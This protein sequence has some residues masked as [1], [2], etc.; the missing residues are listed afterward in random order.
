MSPFQVATV[1][2]KTPWARQGCVAVCA[3]T[4]LGPRPW[5]SAVFQQPPHAA[6]GQV[7]PDAPVT[8]NGRLMKP[9]VLTT[10]RDRLVVQ[11]ERNGVGSLQLESV[12]LQP[13]PPSTPTGRVTLELVRIVFQLAVLEEVRLHINI[14]ELF[15]LWK[16][17]YCWNERWL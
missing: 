7:P 14:I 4:N 11:V 12:E 13:R 16:L 8:G 2:L 1:A 9:P 10:C 17:V 15:F 3:N 6:N 5:E